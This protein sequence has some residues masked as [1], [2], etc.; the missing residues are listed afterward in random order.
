M[1]LEVSAS[2]STA[3]Q[4]RRRLSAPGWTI[5]LVALALA[6]WVFALVLMSG[7]DEGPGTPLHELPIFI[8]GWVV[9]LTAMMLPSELNYV[10]AF[11]AV[12][13]ARGGETGCSRLM[14]C[15]VAGY[16]IAWIAYGLG[17]YSLDLAVRSLSPEM[18]SW[19]RAGPLLAGSVLIGAGIYQMSS[20]K[21]SCLMG[22]RSPLTFFMRYWR[23]GNLGAVAM[24][25]RHGL[26][27]VGCCWAMMAVMFAVG[28]MSLTWMALLS[29]FMFGEKVLP[30]GQ[31]LAIPIACFLW[32]MGGWIAL[33]PGTAPLLKTPMMFASICRG[34]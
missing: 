10:G 23:R 3:S 11:V 14:A 31:K 7:M 26:V 34:L 8:L 24:G 33:F 28:A 18:V 13:R 22:C 16:A 9:M 19:D 4:L 25:V 20:L 6:A 5:I 15:F 32:A 27:C 17:A 1:N 12:L 21:H 2:P 29:L 30:E